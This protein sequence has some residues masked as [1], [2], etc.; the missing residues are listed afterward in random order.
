MKLRKTPIASAVALALMGVVYPVHAQEQAATAA[1]PSAPSTQ[2][3]KPAKTKAKPNAKSDA[4]AVTSPDGA[5]TTQRSDTVGIGSGGSIATSTAA[6]LFPDRILLAQATP[7]P[8]PTPTPTPAPGATPTLSVEVTGLRNSLQRSLETKRNADGVT[9]VVTAEEIGKLPDKN[10]ADAVQR[11]SGVTISSAAGGEGGFD[12]NDRVSLRGTSPSLTQTLVNGHSIASGDWFVLDQVGTVGRSVS[13]TLLPS[14]LVGQVIVRKSATADLVEGGVAGAVDIITRKPL[15]FSKPFSGYVSAQG[16]YADLPEKWDP[17]FSGLLN[18]KNEANTLGVMLQAFYEKRHLRRDGQE[19]LGYGTVAPGSALA[20]AHPDLTNAAYPTLIGSSFFEQERERS[21][22]MI[23][24]QV[25][26]T[27]ALTLDFSAFYSKL[28]ATNYNRNWMF[29]GSHVFN[30]G[31]GEIPTAYTLNNGTITSAVFPNLG[32]AGNNHQYAIVDEIYRPGAYSDTSF[33]N[34]DA[35]WHVNDRFTVYG[36]GGYTKGNGK[37]PKQDVFEGDV[38]NT[39]ASYQMHG[40]GSAVDVSFPNGN[41]SN[42]AGTSLD[43]IFGASPA[44]TEDKE[45]YGRLDG[46]YMIQSGAWTSV[47]FGVRYAEH[48]RTT[49]QVG[50]GPNFTVDPF[51]PANL[52]VWNGETYPGNFAS[53][54]GGN[55]PRNP[56]QLSPGE[57]ERWGDFYSNRDPVTRRFWPGEFE[58]KEKTPAAYVMAN[59]DGKGWSANFGVRFVQTKERVLVNVAIPTSVCDVFKPCPQVPGA[60][61]TSAFGSFYQQ[62]IEHT[63]NDTLPSANL[64]IDLTKDLVARFAAARVMARPD[65]S[66]LGGAI[67]AD[68]TTHTGNG[69]N[70]DL[71]PIRSNNFDA[72]LEWYYQPRALLAAGLFYMDLQDYVGFGVHPTQLLNIRTGTFD[73]YQISSPVNTSGKVKGLELSWQQELGLGFG[74]QANYTYADASEKG[75][76]ALIGASQNVYNII[77]YWENY[78]WSARLAY[79]F[80]SH[81][82]V[83]LDRSTEEFQ[84]DTGTLAASVQYRINK[85]FALTFDGL[86]L[87]D[88]TLKYYAANTDQPRAFYKNGRQY[89]FGLRYDF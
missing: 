74:V 71:K 19:T 39:G 86:N 79:T 83:G 34:L 23:D 31:A 73:T 85:N 66:A 9:E 45:G 54:I 80:R 3:G 75:G 6:I 67:T 17:Q 27:T 60:I 30:G 64:R 72:G 33:Y 4:P 13:F 58:I 55:F 35:T 44:S 46:E 57:L 68:D 82:F 11:L 10:I 38:F 53:G 47:K 16:V 65:Y 62:P 1:T 51:N 24:V 89:Y 7:A 63:Y 18:F 59:L 70:P 42:F 12:E 81:F 48:E 88:P 61:T 76:H 28:K 5:A 41:P 26:P 37:T 8:G 15:D 40:I 56:W 49:H 2:T 87:N 52:P 36:Q 25:K 29:W 22:G 78:G 84:D 32:S 43:W 77:G 20:T 69:G 14:E 21:G 50:Q